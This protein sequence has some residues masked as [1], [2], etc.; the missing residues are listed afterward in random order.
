MNCWITIRTQLWVCSSQLVKFN[1]C[2]ADDDIIL[3]LTCSNDFNEIKELLQR[4]LLHQFP[5]SVTGQLLLTMSTSP[6]AG[7]VLV[8]SL[9]K[10]W[11]AIKN[12]LTF[13]Q[14][15]LL[16]HNLAEVTHHSNLVC[17]KNNEYFSNQTSDSVP[18]G[19]QE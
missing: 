16:L 5:L 11:L 6:L 1:T 2:S 15:R 17:R 9:E 13:N 10:N 18:H 3:G 8:D 7:L 12:M 19:E 4:T 14:W